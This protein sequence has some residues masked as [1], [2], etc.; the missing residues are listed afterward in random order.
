M[1]LNHMTG[2]VALLTA[3][4]LALSA[5]GASDKAGETAERLLGEARAAVDARDWGLALALTAEIDSTCPGATAQRREGMAVRAV[6]TE[7]MLVEDLADTDSLLAVNRL[8][9]DS[10]RRALKRVDTPV[11]GYWTAGQAAGQGCPMQLRL[12][13]NGVMTV[14]VVTGAGRR[15][16]TSVTLK[17]NDGREASLPEQAVDGELNEVSGGRQTA[18]WTGAACDTVGAL[19]ADN[20]GCPLMV[21][22]PGSDQK[23]VRLTAAQVDAMARV[24]R[25]AMACEAVRRLALDHERLEQQLAVARRQVA[26]TRPDTAAG[27]E[28]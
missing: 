2:L 23:P 20:A 10:L 4:G 21:T 13:P 14:T 6:A 19:I 24:Y 25:A 12:D 27:A 16:F 17:G 1:K 3:A 22:F 18:T 7:G 9:A 11:G 8:L 5:C 28:R 15:P 26:V